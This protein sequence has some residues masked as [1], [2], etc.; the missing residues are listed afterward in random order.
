MLRL[1]FLLF[2]VIFFVFARLPLYFIN[3]VREMLR[4]QEDRKRIWEIRKNFLIKNF[5][6][7]LVFLFIF[8]TLGWGALYNVVGREL[9]GGRGLGG[10]GKSEEAF[11]LVRSSK[12]ETFILR[13][14]NKDF[15]SEEEVVFKVS[16]T[17]KL[18]AE[19]E[20]VDTSGSTGQP[21]SDP[22]SSSTTSATPQE[23]SADSE[24]QEY[25][26]ESDSSQPKVPEGTESA[27]PEAT[28]SAQPQRSKLASKFR[29]LLHAAGKINPV[30]AENRKKDPDIKVEIY[31]VDGNE[32]DF[33]VSVELTDNDD[34]EVKVNKGRDFRP[35][36]YKMV[37]ALVDPESGEELDSIEQDFT[38]GVLAINT[39]KSIYLPE[40]EAKLQIAVLDEEGMMVCDAKLRLEIRNPKSEIRNLST[41]EGTIKVNPEC[42]L[43]D[44]TLVPDYEATYQVEGPGTYEMELTAE[45]ENGTHTITDSFE[46][47]SEVPFDVE[48]ETATRI[49]PPETYP[50]TFSIK[51]NQDFRGVVEEYVPADFQI[52]CP[53]LFDVDSGESSNNC[54]ISEEDDVKKISWFVDWEQGQEATLT[55]QFKTP[56]LSP[57]FYL[58]GPLMFKSEIRN[59]KSETNPNVQNSNELDGNLIFEE[60]RRWQLA[61]DDS[62]GANSPSS[63][64]EDT[65]TGSIS[66]SG[67]TNV[68]SNDSSYATVS[69]EK[70]ISY[71]IKATNFGFSLSNCDTIDG[72]YVEVDRKTDNTSYAEDY[73]VRLVNGS[74][75]I[76]GDNKA[77]TDTWPTSD[78]YQTYGGSTDTWNASLACSDVTNSNFGVVFSSQSNQQTGKPVAVTN[79]VDHI[80]ATIYYTA[81]GPTPAIEQSHYRWRDDSYGLNTDNGWQATEDNEYSG[82][83]KSTTARLRMEVDNTGDAEAS[84]YQYLLEYAAQG[85]DSCGGESYTAVPVTAST[86]PFEIVASSQ[87]TDGD[88]ITSGFLTGS[89]T[90][91]NGKGVEDASNKTGSYSLTNGYYTEFEYAIQATSDAVDG[92]TY[93]FRLTNDGSTATFTYNK[94]AEA[95]IPGISGS[96]GKSSDGWNGAIPVYM[97]L[98]GLS[99]STYQYARAKVDTPAAETY[100]FDMSWDSG[101]SRYEGT[102]YPGSYYCNGC[103]DPSTGS[104]T[105]TVQLDD[106]SNFGSV[107]YS[108]SAGSFDTYITRRKSSYDTSNDYTDIKPVWN[109][110]HWD[111]DVAD[112]AL[113][114]SSTQTDAVIAVPFHPTTASITNI[115]VSYDSTS[116]SEGSAESTGDAWWWD[117]DYNTLYLMFGSCST[118][119]VDVDISFDSDTDLWATRFDRVQTA[120]MGE[121]LF[122]N[123]MFIG[124]QYW[125][126]SVY[127][128]GHE[129]A[130]EQAE[131]RAKPS[132]GDEVTVDCMERVS[133]FVDDDGDSGTTSDL[134]CDSSGYYECNVKW[135]QDEWDTYIVSEDNDKIVI[136]NNEDQTTSTGWSQYLDYS[137]SVERVQTFYAGKVYIENNYTITNNDS[138]AHDLDLL[139]EREQWLAGDRATNDRGRYDGDTSDRTMDTRVDMATFTDPWLTSYDNYDT[140]YYA[141]MGF[142]FEDGAEADY[143]IFTDHAFI[144]NTSAEWPVVIGDEGH[145]EAANIGFELSNSSV[146]AGNSVVLNYLQTLYIGSSWS[147][148][149]TQLD[150][151]SSEFNDSNTAPNSPSSLAQKKTDDTVISTGEWIGEDAVKFTATVDDPDDSD[152]LYLCVETDSTG[153]AFSDTE[154]Q[155]GDGVSYSGSS[156]EATVTISSQA[157]DTEYHWQARVK[158]EAGEYSSW[159]SYGGNSDPG[160]TDYAIDTTAPT[161][162]TV[163]DGTE[164]GVDKDFNDESLSQLSANWDGFD[165]SVSGLDYYEYSIGTTQGGTDVVG[166]T[167]NGTATSVTE[168]GLTLQT[169]QPYYFNVRAVDNAGNTQSPA[170]S[171]DGQLVSPSIS[172]SVTPS[173]VTF[174]ALNSSN[175]Y[176]DTEE[177]TLETSTNAYNGYVIRGYASDYLRSASGNETVPDFDGGT[178][179]EPDGWLSEDRGFGYHSSDTSIQ[180]EN[181][182]NSDPCPGGNSPPCYAPFSQTG[183]GDIVA[184]YTANVTGSPISNEQFTLTYKV[185]TDSIQASS[186]YITTIIYTITPQY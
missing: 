143:G 32:A 178:Y 9:L 76:V 20:N 55:Y 33:S 124:N 172:F 105:V 104:F 125:T 57:Q 15:G 159:V 151:A 45:T 83:E 97:T 146:G 51:V 168:Q 66:W 99:E 27:T 137:I 114:C 19:L 13:A 147:D 100:Y 68:Y 92:E 82:L 106:D 52:K 174:D 12:K 179:T 102:I 72:I 28:I 101:D 26:E 7:I 135:A 84:S 1:F 136:E 120:D 119:I 182:F 6:F 88:D 89:G 64:A 44:F 42:E 16:F 129:G 112:F 48:R 11:G 75:T 103:A 161:G 127:G 91:A 107:D 38:W 167:N 141:S 169:S 43:H 149:E 23:P 171:S 138:S 186:T 153:T 93:C 109:T 25:S 10:E 156:V 79:S 90:W 34:F 3:S 95:T 108:D 164:T 70:T 86:E 35:G 165:A 46:V 50:L 47:R 130:G 17:D 81:S 29:N 36:K 134:N 131:S 77:K 78:A 39:T 31:D 183:P 71:Y 56:S 176:T 4:S 8:N 117:S 53:P 73:S 140:G 87:Y 154:D 128:G 115:A 175:N 126:T 110:D 132:G 144:T 162:G 173:T 170:V 142:I 116:V 163:Y 85:G 41:E 63:A 123:G 22:E 118:T 155:C 24:E 58:L 133:V 121:R 62:E 184:D 74:G 67:Y 80:R 40:E 150:D 148:L 59:S 158:D 185:Q 37:V 54:R 96:L 5:A 166:W 180:G 2:L 69:L 94:Y 111:I 49:Y 152:T 177:I 21:I 30:F 65:S 14:K 18:S 98:T 139:H 181:I 122:Y 145:N 157:D 61:I 160:D 113:Y 60:A